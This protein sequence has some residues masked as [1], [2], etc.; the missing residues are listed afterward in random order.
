[1]SWHHTGA[2]IAWGSTRNPVVT[3]LYWLTMLILLVAL[4]DLG[5]GGLL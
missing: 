5:G 2:A 1:M 3:F 4:V